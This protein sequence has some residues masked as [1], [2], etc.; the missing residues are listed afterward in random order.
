M[1]TQQKNVYGR[2]RC[3]PVPSSSLTWQIPT[4]I[5]NTSGFQAILTCIR[6]APD[7]GSSNQS[8][9][10]LGPLKLLNSGSLLA[11]AEHLIPACSIASK[12]PVLLSPLKDCGNKRENHHFGHQT[13]LLSPFPS[14]SYPAPWQR[15]HLALDHSCENCPEVPH[16]S[17]L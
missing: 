4:T 14:L 2:P 7:L 10:F 1:L 17:T 12:L 9:L 5:S 11:E 16:V 3:R 6:S 8:F 13:L 15:P